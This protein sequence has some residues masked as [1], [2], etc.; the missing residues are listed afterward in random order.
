VSRARHTSPIPPAPMW[1]VTSYGPSRAPGANDT[2]DRLNYMEMTFRHWIAIG[3]RRSDSQVRRRLGGQSW[4]HGWPG[5][6]KAVSDIHAQ[7]PFWIGG[8]VV[9]LFR[10]VYMTVGGTAK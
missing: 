8:G 9:P 4:L 6:A 1:A 10:P 5:D 3:K 2:V 7:P